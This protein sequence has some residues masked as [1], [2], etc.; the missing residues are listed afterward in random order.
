MGFIM[1]I[2]YVAPDGKKALNPSI[3]FIED[4][5]RNAGEAYWT[6]QTGAAGIYCL[7]SGSQMMLVVNESFGVLIR[8]CTESGDDEFV[9]INEASKQ[10][11]REVSVY[12]GGDEWVVPVYY[13]VS[14]DFALRIIEEF[15][16]TGTMSKVVRWIVLGTDD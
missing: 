11:D 4:V 2:E 1:I 3:C 8:F 16:K 7:D 6:Y 12:L 10:D 15:L 5:I 13:F 14:I 9:S